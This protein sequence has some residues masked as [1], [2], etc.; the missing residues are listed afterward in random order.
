MKLIETDRFLRKFELKEFPQPDIIMLRY[1]VLMCHGYG[2]I[3]GLVKPSLLHE[4]CIVLRKCGIMAFAPNIVP[5]A[6][7][8]IRARQWAERIQQ[9]KSQYEFEKLNVVA[10]SMGGLDMRYAISELGIEN[11]VASLTTV[12]T[13]HRGTSLAN[14]V[15]STPEL[16]KD[17]LAEFFD[18][19]GDNIY[20]SAK[21]DAIAAVEQLT[22]EYIQ[23][24]FNQRIK[25]SEN[26][27]YFSVS[28]AV[29]KGT[30]KHLN[31]IFRYQNQ[32]IY[33]HEGQN[34]SFVS[35]ESAKWGEHLKTVSLSHLEQTNI[36]V[37][38]ERQKLVDEFWISLMNHLSEKGF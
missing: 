5:Y 13:P 37:A 2:A 16:V 30:K 35:V 26:I 38:K 1:P 12:S 25:N 20:P 6:T 11:S 4:P 3:A 18:W 28:A 36:K 33:Q 7:I 21:S 23:D 17:K 31:A 24:D 19:F 34:D 32:Y 27:K 9:L 22:C 10:H 29:G 15:L 14:F 8:E